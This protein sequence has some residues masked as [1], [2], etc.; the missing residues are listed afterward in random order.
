M[1]KL[2][3]AIIMVLGIIT[4]HGQDII[5]PADIPSDF[6]STMVDYIETNAGTSILLYWKTDGLLDGKR[7]IISRL[8]DSGV[9][10][11]VDS[12]KFNNTLESVEYFWS[13]IN[14]DLDYPHLY[15]L[16][17]LDTGNRV[18]IAN[19]VLIGALKQEVPINIIIYK[20]ND[21]CEFRTF[22]YKNYAQKI[23]IVNYY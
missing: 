10:E 13:D 19:T 16:T 3:F 12:I 11:K 22:V 23:A 20:L 21:F 15:R 5:I 9:W 8:T 1:K 14:I 2:I 7:F 4:A 6:D 18:H 17:I